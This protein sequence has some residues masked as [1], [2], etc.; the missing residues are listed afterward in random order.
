MKHYREASKYVSIRS[1]ETATSRYRVK[2]APATDTVAMEIYGFAATKPK[3]RF[4]GRA[5]ALIKLHT[6]G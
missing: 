2:G 6:V 1:T 4:W 3:S 5:Q